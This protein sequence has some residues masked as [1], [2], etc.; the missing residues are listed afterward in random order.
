LATTW[1]FRRALRYFW[2]YLL[3]RKPL[4]LGPSFWK[5]KF[6]GAN[7][8]PPTCVEVSLM[9][10]RRP[11]LRRPSSRVLNSPGRNWMMSAD[12]GGGMRRLSTP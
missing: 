8:V 4:I 11:V 7:K 9:A 1:Y 5:A 6:D 12:F 3:K 10:L 2:P